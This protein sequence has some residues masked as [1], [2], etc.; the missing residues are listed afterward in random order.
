M[1]KPKHPAAVKWPQKVRQYFEVKIEYIE[2]TEEEFNN[3][4]KEYIENLNQYFAEGK[5][6]EE[7]IKQGL[8]ELKYDKM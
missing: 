7:D 1:P 3:K 6:L 4:M 2:L 8:G 5:Q